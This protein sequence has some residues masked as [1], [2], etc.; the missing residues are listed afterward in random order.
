MAL[1][2]TIIIY[3]Q[4]LS[5]GGFLNMSPKAREIF[6]K[7]Q[8]AVQSAEQIEDTGAS[9]SDNPEEELG[10]SSSRPSQIRNK[11]LKKIGVDG[12]NASDCEPLL[13]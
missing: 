1:L 12:G 6:S 5:G 11:Y 3:L 7:K 13:E 9:G 8:E 10:P 2:A 4:D